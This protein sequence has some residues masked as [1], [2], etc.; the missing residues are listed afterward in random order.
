MDIISFLTT[1]LLFPLTQAPR[2]RGK[3]MSLV[4]KEKKNSGFQEISLLIRMKK[5]FP[6]FLSL[7]FL[8]AAVSCLL[9]AEM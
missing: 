3:E 1:K 6:T 7:P 4:L 8:S 2:F 5:K 9:L